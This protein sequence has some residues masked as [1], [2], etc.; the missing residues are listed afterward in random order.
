MSV[1]LARAAAV[2]HEGVATDTVTLDYAGRFLR[3]RRLVSDGGR[4][5]LVDLAQMVALDDG[6]L[7]RLD[8]GT[9]IAVRAAPEALLAVTGDL[10]R[11]AWHVGNRHAPCQIEP[12][13][14]LIQ[15]DPVME[16]MLVRLGAA[17][18][19]VTAPFFPERGA[20]GQ[21]RTHGHDHSHSHG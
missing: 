20:Y 10:T 17:V 14:I 21:G 3:R 19:P 5:F 4:L 2:V 1:A 6:D 8:D 18:A 12:D 11:A 13:R 9:L 15:R 16:D 7:L